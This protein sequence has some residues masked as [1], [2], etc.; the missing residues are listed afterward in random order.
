MDFEKSPSFGFV[1]VEKAE[2]VA[3]TN[4]F[5]ANNEITTTVLP[6]EVTLSWT[7]DSLLI[8]SE[9]YDKVRFTIISE[10]NDEST[11]NKTKPLAFPV[12]IL[13]DVNNP[14][15]AAIQ[16]LA[17]DNGTFNTV[18]DSKNH[19]WINPESLEST[20]FKIFFNL[21]KPYNL[22]LRNGNFTL[23]S[24]DPGYNIEIFQFENFSVKATS[25]NKTGVNLSISHRFDDPVLADN[26]HLNL[27]FN[28]GTTPT[29][30]DLLK[31]SSIKLYDNDEWI[32]TATITPGESNTASDI[33][34]SEAT[35]LWMLPTCTLNHDDQTYTFPVGRI[36]AERIPADTPT[37]IFT[38]SHDATSITPIY[39]TLQGIRI[40]TPIPGNIYIQVTGSKACKVLIP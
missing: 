9:D 18:L 38:F 12:S 27:L 13:Y 14:K 26:M 32:N 6:L 40:E 31:A 23:R 24:P 7:G 8:S 3:L 11:V 28:D 17:T 39:Y 36:L 34:P 33:D 22:A 37:A 25:V 21:T 4:S 19:P 1:F 5:V 20:H 15:K 2:S 30:D 35:T 16:M 10:C 29:T